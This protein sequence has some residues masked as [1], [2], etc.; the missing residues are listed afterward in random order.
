M[1]RRYNIYNIKAYFPAHS[2]DFLFNNGV[3]RAAGWVE[4]RNNR[5]LSAINKHQDLRYMQNR[6]EICFTL[7]I[8][9]ISYR[10]NMACVNYCSVHSAFKIK[11]QLSLHNS[12]DFCRRREKTCL[13]SICNNGFVSATNEK[14]S[15]WDMQVAKNE[16]FK[17]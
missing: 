15:Q 16:S 3:R 9:I 11:G 4:N 10:Q 6:K 7:G 8:V 13:C 2:I 14:Q 17:K 5:F 1:T 12:T